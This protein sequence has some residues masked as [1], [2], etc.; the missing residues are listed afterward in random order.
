MT[1]L[2]QVIFSLRGRDCAP[3]EYAGAWAA[4][5]PIHHDQTPTLYIWEGPDEDIH[6]LCRVPG[7]PLESICDA[8]EIDPSELINS[9]SFVPFREFPTE[10][11]PDPIR[12]FVE[13]GARAIGCS[14]SYLALP[15]LSALAAAIGGTRQLRLKLGLLNAEETAEVLTISPRKL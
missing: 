13:V 8:I 6:I 7:C 12:E 2:Q 5:C 10:V 1:S 9:K 14:S 4:I 11:L 3:K 15:L